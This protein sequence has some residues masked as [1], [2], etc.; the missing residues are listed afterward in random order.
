M[1]R[2]KLIYLIII[3]IIIISLALFR[4]NNQIMKEVIQLEKLIEKYDN[5]GRKKR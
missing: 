2:N 3:I 1:K 5:E 4:I